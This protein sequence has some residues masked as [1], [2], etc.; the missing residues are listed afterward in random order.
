MVPGRGDS[1]IIDGS[2]FGFSLYFFG[3]VG[4]FGGDGVVAYDLIF[5][6]FDHDGAFFLFFPVL[7]IFLLGGFSDFEVVSIL[8]EIFQ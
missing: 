4:D 2:V 3:R 6:V 8:P 5:D 7:F 1:F